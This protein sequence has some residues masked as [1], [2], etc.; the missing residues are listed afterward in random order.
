VNDL[1]RADD[2]FD[3][4]DP[5]CTTRGE[6]EIRL[7]DIAA[8]QKDTPFANYLLDHDADSTI[9]HHGTQGFL[10]P[11]I[12]GRA[13]KAAA[14]LQITTLEASNATLAA[15]IAALQDQLRI[16][17]THLPPVAGLPI[18]VVDPTTVPGYSLVGT[19]MHDMNNP[20]S[21][22]AVAAGGS[23]YAL[24][25]VGNASIASA[26]IASQTFAAMAAAPCLLA[27]KSMNALFNG[28]VSASKHLPAGLHLPD[29]EN[30]YYF[31]KSF[32]VAASLTALLSTA[33]FTMG[34][35]LPIRAVLIGLPCII[36]V[37][38]MSAALG[39]NGTDRK[40]IRQELF[41]KFHTTQ[42]DLNMENW[43]KVGSIVLGMWRNEGIAVHFQRNLD[44]STYERLSCLLPG[45]GKLKAE[46]LHKAET[47]ATAA[48][49]AAA[50]YNVA[51]LKASYAA[52]GHRVVPSSGLNNNCAIHS[53]LMHATGDFDS[54]HEADAAVY[55]EWLVANFPDEVR[56]A[57]SA[58]MSDMQHMEALIAK[59]NQDHGTDMLVHFV[60]AD[61]AGQPLESVGTGTGRDHV[62]IFDQMGH[63]EALLP[64]PVIV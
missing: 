44:T 21:M 34:L 53:L 27:D 36:G 64:P 12:A 14:T 17:Q 45:S 29:R 46:Q 32:G 10:Q 35:L 52:T 13:E 3:L 56:N 23:L 58:L 19:R 20:L 57:S 40:A 59:I 39:N 1:V 5:L 63:F 62:R 48:R 61:A 60:V 15:Q 51:I 24:A 43:G 33:A 16:A 41:A 30:H 55:K 9:C 38:L 49:I 37:G 50:R 54:S 7:L 47:I 2:T 8:E 26:Y 18:A 31:T 25:M 22:L 4:N 11:I 42:P 6:G 28:A